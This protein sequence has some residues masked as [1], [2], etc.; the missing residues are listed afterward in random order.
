MNTNSSEEVSWISWFC[1]L[2]GNEFFHLVDEDYIKDKFS[3]TGLNEKVPQYRL[4]MILNLEL[5]IGLS[6]IPS[7]AMVKLYCLKCLDMY[8]HK[9]LR[10]Q[11]VDGIYFGTGF[12]HMLFMVHPNT[13]QRGPPTRLCPG[14]MVSRSKEQSTS[15]SSKPL[16][17]SRALL[18]RFTDSSPDLTLNL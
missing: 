18:R 12:P 16:A 3:V 17:T 1:E 2:L 6:D 7:E 14:S 8:T 15:S 11:N 4:R 10:H 9:S 13:G 5:V